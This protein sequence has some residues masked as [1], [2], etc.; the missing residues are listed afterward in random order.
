V[1][2]AVGYLVLGRTVIQVLLL[3]GVVTVQSVSLVWEVLAFFVLGLPQTA[4][5]SIFVRTFYAMQNAK[6]PFY[7]VT[8]LVILNAAI[9]I[10]LFSWLG[11]GGLALGQ[12]IVYSVAIIVA[13]RLL[14]A[15]V[16]GIDAAGAVRCL[17]RALPA[18]LVMGAILWI[19]D[20]VLE[21]WFRT[22]ALTTGLLVLVFLAALGMAMY[23]SLS[24]LLGA[25]EVVYVSRLFRVRSS[26][27]RRTDEDESPQPENER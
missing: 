24:R 19:V 12:S 22:A 5:F 11:V 9:N 6:T 17:A 1:P 16:G 15:R 13:G 3:N 18:A 20:R 23:L 27:G 21:D 8:G 14:A 4:I 7:I 26:A 10:P 2:A 25:Q